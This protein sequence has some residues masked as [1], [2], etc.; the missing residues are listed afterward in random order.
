MCL[1]II[2]LVVILEVTIMSGFSV[3]HVLVLGLSEDG[4]YL[5][6]AC[7]QS[8]VDCKDGFL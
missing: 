7:V 1:V 4:Y 8:I 5:Q 2:G 3:S 6:V